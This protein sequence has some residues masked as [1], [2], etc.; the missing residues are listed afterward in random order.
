MR[1]TGSGH[2]TSLYQQRGFGGL[3]LPHTESIARRTMSL[4]MFPQMKIEQ[5]ERVAQN[6]H[7]HLD[8]IKSQL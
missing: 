4:P 6:L 8:Q 5:V 2:L 1:R 3:C 7:R